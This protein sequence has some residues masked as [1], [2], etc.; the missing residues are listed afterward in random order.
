MYLRRC[1]CRR[2]P[3][4]FYLLDEAN[5]IHSRTASPSAQERRVQQGLGRRLSLG[6]QT[7]FLFS[8]LFSNNF[9]MLTFRQVRRDRSQAARNQS[10]AVN[11]AIT[12]INW[13]RITTFC[14]NGL[15]P[16][17]ITPSTL[18]HKTCE[19]CGNCGSGSSNIHARKVNPCKERRETLICLPIRISRWL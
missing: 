3:N 11:A 4:T 17:R 1:L 5:G 19:Y 13:F 9:H 6:Q 12:G 18:A 7:P 15:L 2:M 16:P 8:F 10:N 14:C